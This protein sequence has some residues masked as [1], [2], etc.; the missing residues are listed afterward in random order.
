MQRQPAQVLLAL[1]ALTSCAGLQTPPHIVV[2]LTDDLGGR[3]TAVYGSQDV[4][5]PNIERL[6]A[7][8]MTFDRAFVASP[9]CAPSRAALMTGL[10]PARN[11]AEANHTYHHEGLAPLTASLQELGYEIAAFGKVVH[12]DP[13]PEYAWDFYKRPPVGLAENVAEYFAERDSSAPL[14]LLVGDRRPHVPWTEE[15]VYDPEHAGLPPYFVDT[16]ETREHRAR[17]FSDIT[18]LDEEFGKVMDLAQE[19]LGQ[20]I[21]Y[22]FTSDH[23]G[24]WPF[25]KWNLYDAGI[26]VPLVMAWE[27]RIAPGKRADAMVSWIDLLPTLIDLAGGTVPEGIDGRSFAGVLRGGDDSHR[28]AIFTTHSGDG[29]F[30]VYPM[31]SIRTKQFKYI[32]NLLPDH[33]HTNHSDILRKDG[34]GAFWDSWDE[35]AATDP[36]AAAIVERYFVRPPEELFDLRADELEQNNLAEHADYEGLADQLRSRLEDWMAGQGD[37]RTVFNEPYPTTGPYPDAATVG[38]K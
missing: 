34:A 32:L 25:G 29:V 15:S 1:I 28:E 14:C 20:D 30:N 16:R 19:N 2:F 3:D 12:G 9:A 37:Q 8:G 18:G 22:A 31:R 24:Q 33:F 11:G 21:V 4:R 6:A 27:G 10:M 17:Y 35:A 13:K 26:R 38:R 23:G 7:M 36:A 5:T